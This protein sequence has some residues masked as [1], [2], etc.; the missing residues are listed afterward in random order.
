MT[1]EWGLKPAQRF[2]EYN[3]FTRINGGNQEIKLQEQ[4][5]KVCLLIKSTDDKTVEWQ[6][7]KDLIQFLKEEIVKL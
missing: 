6:K 3:G 2:M 1:V 7:N 4:N 5:N